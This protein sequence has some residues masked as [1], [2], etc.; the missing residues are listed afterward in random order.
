MLVFLYYA[1][2]FTTARYDQV[3]ASESIILTNANQR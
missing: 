3:D 2:S 1:H